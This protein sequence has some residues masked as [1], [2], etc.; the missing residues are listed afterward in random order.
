MPPTHRLF[1]KNGKPITDFEYYRLLGAPNYRVLRQSRPNHDIEVTTLWVGYSPAGANEGEI[2]ESTAVYVP[3][4]RLVA[5]WGSK[6]QAEALRR[7]EDLEQALK[8]PGSGPETRAA[9]S[10]S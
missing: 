3:T 10:A 4:R 6:S 1:D 2:F 9:L 7:H 5:Q 8:Q